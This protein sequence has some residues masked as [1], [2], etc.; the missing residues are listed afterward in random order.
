MESP[1][2]RKKI[3]NDENKSRRESYDEGVGAMGAVVKENERFIQDQGQRQKQAIEVQDKNLESLGL[4]VDR[5]G[6]IGKDINQE[7]KEQNILLDGL[8][9]DM[10]DA[11][12]KMNVVMGSLQKLLK[13]KDGCQIWTIVVLALI[14]IILGEINLE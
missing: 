11:D 10:D 7:L 4:A 13:T 2:V 3:E 9:K 8:E 12:S 14:L 1:A 5:L 6:Q